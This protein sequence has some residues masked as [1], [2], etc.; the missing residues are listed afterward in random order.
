MKRLLL[1]FLGT[2]PTCPPIP[3]VWQQ[4]KIFFVD[5]GARGGPPSNWLCLGG[6]ITYV[7]F[8]PD[9]EEALIIKRSFADNG[10]YRGLVFTNAIGAKQCVETLHLTQYRPSSSLLE[11]NNDVLSKMAVSSF[12]T[13]EQKI[14]VT[15]T[16]LDSALGGA[17]ICAD[18]LKIDVQGFELEVLRGAESALH[19][20]I[21]CEI[22]ASFIEVY[23]HQ[24]FFA[25][26]DQF[27]RSQGFFLAD[28]ERFWWR[29]KGVPLEIQERGSISYGNAF[30]LKSSVLEPSDQTLAVKA[31]IICSAMG[32]DELSWEIVSMASRNGHLSEI[33]AFNI[34]SWIR[35]RRK[36]STFWFKMGE[37]LHKLIGRQTLGRWLSLWG[38][39]LQGNSHTGS[40]SEGWSRR[41]SW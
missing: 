12:Y 9:P 32:L 30:Y 5:V 34:Q 15:L 36:R 20:I 22:E 37:R 3:E 28:L 40:D 21:G 2:L 27:M 18:F 7:C 25:D 38:R 35:K 24:S 13:V 14:P 26:V 16:T 1:K 31:S 11:P 17:Q 29:R 39:A 8:E 6:D 33:D 41:S 4:Q 19:N 10:M 23:K